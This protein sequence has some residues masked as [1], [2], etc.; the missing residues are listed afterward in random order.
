MFRQMKGGNITILRALP[1][2]EA[3]RQA[4]QQLRGRCGVSITSSRHEALRHLRDWVF[5]NEQF[6]ARYQTGDVS[7]ELVGELV[8][9]L[10]SH[11]ALPQRRSAP[12]LFQEALLSG[13]A[14]TVERLTTFG[15]SA[16]LPGFHAAA[17][18]TLQELRH[19]RVSPG[20]L[21]TDERRAADLA[22]L[23]DQLDREL[24][25]HR[26]STLSHRIERLVD[27]E[28]SLPQGLSHILWIGEDEWPPIFITLLDWLVRAGCKVS[29]LTETHPFDDRFFVAEAALRDAFPDAAIKATNAPVRPIHAVF[30]ADHVAETADS[31]VGIVAAADEFVEV[32]H[33]VRH[34]R[35]RLRQGVAPSDVVLFAPSLDEYGPLLHSTC[36]RLGVPVEM[37]YRAALL[38]NPFARFCSWALSAAVNGSLHAVA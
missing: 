38:T 6:H 25:R 26:L 16:H 22:C 37:D 21:P 32:E 18:H 23:I 2:F 30:A 36:V 15:A 33:A 1:G 3:Q 20:D 14:E 34:T 8:G 24:E 5:Q 12:Q 13:C 31:S 35:S 9:R 19:H 4:A 7:I 28:P 17:V 10:A 29:V 27:T 11:A